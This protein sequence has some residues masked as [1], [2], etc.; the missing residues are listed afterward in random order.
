M[1][2]MSKVK[3]GYKVY[4]KETGKSKFVKHKKQAEDMVKK[5][6]SKSK[7]SYKKN[8]DI[9]AEDVSFDYGGQL[10]KAENWTS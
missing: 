4:N 1:P 6:Y 10:F 5:G 7:A 9:T 2:S 3:G 8:K